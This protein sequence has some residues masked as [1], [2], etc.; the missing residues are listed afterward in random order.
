V[1]TRSPWWRRKWALAL[2]VVLGLGIIG[3]AAGGDDEE[4]AAA[5]EVGETTIAEAPT[6][7]EHDTTATA[8][9]TSAAPQTTTTAAP[10]TTAAPPTVP[11]MTEPSETASQRNARGTAANYLD[12]MSF[13]RTGLIEQ[14]EFEGYSEADA[15]YGVDALH[16][17]WNEQAANKAAEYLD[18]MP[19]SAEYGVST[20][21]L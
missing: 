16:V 19:F 12:F 14:L 5:T 11:P 2:W 15:A 10:A 9:P 6:T 8:P 1:A 4:H 20:T 3:A 7:T 21:G 17:D 18:M 13:S